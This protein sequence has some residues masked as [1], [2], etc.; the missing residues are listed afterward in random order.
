M[1]ASETDIASEVAQD[2]FDSPFASSHRDITYSGRSTTST[3]GIKSGKKP[4][5]IGLFRLFAT[6]FVDFYIKI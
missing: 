1:Y 2:L 4:P 3:I 5:N 6:L